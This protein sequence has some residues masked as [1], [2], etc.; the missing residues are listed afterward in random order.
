MKNN[1]SKEEFLKW[2]SP[3]FGESNPTV[4][5]NKVWEWLVLTKLTAYEA[6]AEMKGPKSFEAG[7]VWC[8]NRFGQSC[9]RLKDG[10]DVY[11]G[12]EHEDHYDPDFNIYNDVI[13]VNDGAVEIYAYP[14]DAFQPTD[15]HSA[16]LVDDKIYILGNLGYWGNRNIG[17]TP[18]YTI[19]LDSY[20]ISKI[21]TAGDNPGWIYEHSAEY[22]LEDNSIVIEGGKIDRGEEYGLL[23]NIDSWKLSLTTLK[24]ERLTQKK[25]QRWSVKRKDDKMLDLFDIRHDLGDLNLEGLDLDEEVLSAFEEINQKKNNLVTPKNKELLKS[26]YSPPLK[27]EILPE[28]EDKYNEYAIEIDGIK[29]RY[30]EE[31]YEI[32]VTIEGQLSQK[33]LNILKKDLLKKLKI[34]Q[35]ARIVLLDIPVF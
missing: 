21:E 35:K 25:W 26:L 14:E 27:H 33:S 7:P 15:F 10:R 23:E 12:G 20:Q 22:Q 16:T 17:E 29:V 28:D 34:I 32:N 5:T 2:R 9:T 24:W 3:A 30:V 6:N 19:D 13:V 8:F 11:I 4:M 18:L 1:I 31:A